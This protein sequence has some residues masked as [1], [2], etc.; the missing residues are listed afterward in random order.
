[1]NKNL[2]TGQAFALLGVAG[3]I[4]PRHLDAIRANGGNL[5]AAMDPSDSVGIL[6]R[7]FPDAKFFT[8]YERFERFLFKKKVDDNPVKFVS[9]CSPNYLHDTHC[10]LALNNGANAVCEKP[11]VLFPENMGSLA[12]LE[13]DTGKSIFC[14][15]QLRL[16]SKIKALKAE[17]AAD[18]STVYEVN[19][20]YITSRG[21]WYNVSWKGDNAK[22][23]GVL[24]NIGIHFFDMLLYVFGEAKS[25]ELL[26]SSDDTAVGRLCCKQANINWKLSTDKSNLPKNISTSTFR[27]IKINDKSLE[28]SEGFTDL[29]QESY[30]A[31]LN[32]N[33]FGLDEVKPSI[34]L[35]SALRS[36]GSGE[37]G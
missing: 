23:G 21:P 15:L 12:Q 28:F 10:R 31:I 19:L 22:S 8:S 36:L 33:G 35:V 9:I 3:Y 20:E 17:V 16:H 6:D 1:M 37:T 32:G 26:F 14:I 34:K 24:F 13:L 27:E 4:A 25:N 29:H 2:T 30:A 11:L 18:K 7:Y 5:I